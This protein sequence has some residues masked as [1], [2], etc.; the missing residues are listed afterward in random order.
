MATKINSYSKVLIRNT[1][2]PD[3]EAWLD[4][5]FSEDE[6][7]ECLESIGVIVDDDECETDTYDLLMSGESITKFEVVGHSSDVLEDKHF[8]DLDTANELVER[9]E[10]IDEYDNELLFAL[11][12]DG[13]ELDEAI[14]TA[15]DVYPRDEETL[16]ETFVRILDENIEREPGLT[17]VLHKLRKEYPHLDIECTC[18][19]CPEQYEIWD[20]N[21]ENYPQIGYFRLRGGQFTVECPDAGGELVYK[22]CPNGCMFFEDEEREKYLRE[23]VVAVL[24]W[25]KIRDEATQKVRAYII[26]DDHRL[27]DYSDVEICSDLDFEIALSQMESKLEEAT[28]ETL[29][30]F[31]QAIDSNTVSYE[32]HG[33]R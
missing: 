30:E 32:K 14:D 25:K 12:A 9:L 4:L 3:R 7:N 27:E 28:N 2:E 13:D 10:D 6:F 11:M 5:P 24:E 22:A 19:A 15:E 23:A 18:S 17:S 16:M 1:K 31:A 29:V 20:S 26:A 8:A 21:D 33:C